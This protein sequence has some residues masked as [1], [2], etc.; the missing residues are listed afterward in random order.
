MFQRSLVNP[1]KNNWAPRVGLAYRITP[2][3]VIRSGYGVSYIHFNR[4]GGEEPARLQSSFVI[5]V[6]I[7]NPDPSRS[8]TCGPS[9]ASTGCFRPTAL[10]Y[11][12]NQINPATYDI[13]NTQL[14]YI[15]ADLRSGYVQSWH[16]YDSAGA[17]PGFS[18]GPGVRGKSRREADDPRRR[19]QARPQAV[20]ENTALNARRPYLGFAGIEEAWA[21]GSPTTTLSRSNW[22]KSIP[23]A[24]I[25]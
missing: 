20:N 3:T 5:D 23:R 7:T 12:A 10:G 18:A 4:L 14:R 17:E 13:S 6:S 2:K 8:S 25:C 16:F 21:A 1:D 15:P 9:V 22:R 19:Q 11:T 24:C